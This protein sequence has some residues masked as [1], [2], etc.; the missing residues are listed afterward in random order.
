MKWWGWSIVGFVATAAAMSAYKRYL[1]RGYGSGGGDLPPLREG[2]VEP[3]DCNNIR[4][5]DDDDFVAWLSIASASI[6]ASATD[7]EYA[8]QLLE[9]IHN[10]PYPPPAPD[11]WRLTFEDDTVMDWFT[12]VGFVGAVRRWHAAL[13]R[14][15]EVLGSSASPEELAD[16]AYP[17]LYPDCPVRLDPNDPTHA[18]CIES[19]V[20]VRNAARAY[21]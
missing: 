7:Q 8:S 21:A 13:S 15:V 14:A 6:P 19:W 16:M 20:A 2:R 11:D 18:D 9:S 3:L 1:Y 17:E 5:V 10:C 12:F 4:V